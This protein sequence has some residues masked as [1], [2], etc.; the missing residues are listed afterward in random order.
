MFERHENHI[1]PFPDLFLDVM[2]FMVVRVQAIPLAE[3]GENFNR[4]T[5]HSL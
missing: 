3:V 2:L 1:F 4:L 5:S